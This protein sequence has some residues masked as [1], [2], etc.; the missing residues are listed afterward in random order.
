MPVIEVGETK[1]IHFA[2]EKVALR[3]IM[4]NNRLKPALRGHNLCRS[5]IR[6]LR[7]SESNLSFGRRGGSITARS[8]PVSD[9][10]RLP[11]HFGDSLNFFRASL[12]KKKLD[13]VYRTYSR[14]IS[15]ISILC[16]TQSCLFTT[17]QSCFIHT[18]DWFANFIAVVGRQAANL[19]RRRRRHRL[20][21]MSA[22]RRHALA[23]IRVFVNVRTG[24]VRFYHHDQHQRHHHRR[25]RRRLRSVG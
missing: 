18:C 25:H 4:H 20:G 16:Q 2:S 14:K 17:R 8:P 9:I 15:T 23:H 24:S 12:V 19:E 22:D 1:I 7:R 5:H 6:S 11:S 10:D 21:M 3:Q 13:I